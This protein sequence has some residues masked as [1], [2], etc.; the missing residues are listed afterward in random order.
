MVCSYSWDCVTALN[1][2]WCESGGRPNAIGGG[3][4]YGL[5]QINGVHARKYPNFWETWM[6][7]ATNISWAYSIW[8]ASGWRPWGCAPY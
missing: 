8:S 4:N 3:A 6:D 5:F 7:P 1:V 2:M